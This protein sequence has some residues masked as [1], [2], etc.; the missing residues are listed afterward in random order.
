MTVAPL[1]D[2]YPDVLDTGVTLPVEVPPWCAALHKPPSLPSARLQQQLDA[3]SLFAGYWHTRRRGVDHVFVRHSYY[4]AAEVYGDAK[5]YTARATNGAAVRHNILCQAALAAPVLLWDLANLPQADAAAG[6]LPAA[7][8]HPRGGDTLDACQLSPTWATDAPP[9]D[10]D[11]TALWDA[12]LATKG[13]LSLPLVASARA[14]PP[15]SPT[16]GKWTARRVVR[17]QAGAVTLSKHEIPPPLVFVAN[18][19]PTAPALL[20]LAHVHRRPSRRTR[21]AEECWRRLLTLTE[22]HAAASP[23]GTTQHV[24][25]ARYYKELPSLRASMQ[26]RLKSAHGVLCIHNFA[27]QGAFDKV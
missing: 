15:C 11:P 12:L 22:P 3:D 13:H 9:P 16:R 7:R 20:R 24:S 4:H 1:Y 25:L 26:P 23:A 10:V 17:A 18:D 8:D 19:W 6:L 5:T 14:S 27:Y 2:D 21:T